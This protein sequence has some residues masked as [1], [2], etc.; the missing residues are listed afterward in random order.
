MILHRTRRH[1]GPCLC[2]CNLQPFQLRVCL[3]EVFLGELEVVEGLDQR[4]EVV[5]GL[6]QRRVGA[7]R[8]VVVR[9]VKSNFLKYLPCSQRL[10]SGIISN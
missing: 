3:F 5:E 7:G 6:D 4:L 1:S 10:G 8:W 9:G 2:L